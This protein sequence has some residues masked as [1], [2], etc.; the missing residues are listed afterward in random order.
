MY[1]WQ[2]QSLRKENFL[3]FNNAEKGYIQIDIYCHWDLN[4]F[5]LQKNERE[6]KTK[7]V[8]IL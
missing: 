8:N 2:A 3:Y 7:C 1:D 6:K 4:Q 5:T